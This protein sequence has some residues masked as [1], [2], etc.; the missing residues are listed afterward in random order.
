MVEEISV[1]EVDDQEE[2][3]WNKFVSSTK[4]GTPNHI[5]QW[6][7]IIQ[8]GYG[9]DTRFLG[10]FR[11]GVLRAVFPS[12][13]LRLPFGVRRAISL[14]YC[15]YAGVLAAVEEDGSKLRIPS[16]AGSWEGR[17]KAIRSS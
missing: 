14:P 9:L 15:N 6:K 1:R 12:A 17:V 8:E 4:G 2:E 10:A 3:T 5:Y 7:K 13:I 16:P 11:Q